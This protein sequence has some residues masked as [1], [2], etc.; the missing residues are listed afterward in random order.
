[1]TYFLLDDR[2][3]DPNTNPF[4]VVKPE[5]GDSCPLVTDDP[6]KNKS[7]S[8]Y[9][10]SL[11]LYLLNTNIVLLKNYL[12]ENTLRAFFRKIDFSFK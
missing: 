7:S 8:Q 11:T 3:E 4:L 2:L 10:I 1:V 6:G 5:V 9:L 12:K